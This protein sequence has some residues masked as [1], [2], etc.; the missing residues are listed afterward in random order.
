MKRIIAL[1][2]VLSLL[3]AACLGFAEDEEKSIL[4]RLTA[5]AEDVREAGR[6]AASAVSEKVGQ[7][8]ETVSG[9][10]SGVGGKLEDLPG[11]ASEML[12][13]AKE[14]LSDS[15]EKARDAA[16]EKLDQLSEQASDALGKAKDTLTDYADQAKDTATEK[17]D[18]ASDALTDVKDKISECAD[19]AAKKVQELSDKVSGILTVSKM[20]A[21]YY[22]DEAKDTVAQKAEE[23]AEGVSGA[24]EEA[25][26]SLMKA[27]SDV[28]E[29]AVEKL[30]AL[31][32]WL[33]GFVKTEEPVVPEDKPDDGAD[34]GDSENGTDKTD[35]ADKTDD[36]DKTDSS[37]GDDGAA[38]PAFFPV[39]GHGFYFGMTLAEAQ[40]LNV[41]YLNDS[42]ANAYERARALV[43][44]NEENTGLYFL[45]FAGDTDDAHL[46]EVDEFAFAAQDTLI[47]PQ[48]ADGQYR[49]ST[50]ETT[51]QQVYSEKASSCG[52]R[53]GPAS[54]LESG[55][56]TSSLMF[57]EIDAGISRT[58]VY[59]AG[60]QAGVMLVTHFVYT[61]DCGVNVVIYQQIDSSAA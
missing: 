39:S 53:F 15:A 25:K 44:L 35:E 5:A 37:D 42:R 52:Q 33:K 8:S 34:I 59:L 22:I 13:D 21:S 4:E 19:N 60:E 48:D 50:T 6:E 47:P 55:L 26:T 38:Q 54:D 40:A 36:A 10:L 3:S 45:W 18:Q 51:V 23:W 43:L 12:E 56:L 20:V 32:D 28:Q 11:Q 61:T 1:L 14:K 30:E 24:A 16:A 57:D 31:V 9:A 7:V 58:Q 41:S 17:L 49:I 2:M 46:F 27:L 29:F